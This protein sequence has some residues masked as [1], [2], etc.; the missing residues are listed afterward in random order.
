MKLK[1]IQYKRTWYKSS[2]CFSFTL[3]QRKVTWNQIPVGTFALV[4]AAT[5]ALMPTGFLLGRGGQRAAQF[6]YNRSL[7]LLNRGSTRFGW[8]GP[9][10]GL[11]V[12]SLRRGSRHFDI[13]FTG[14]RSGANA[15]RDG[16]YSGIIG[17]GLSSG[18]ANACSLQQ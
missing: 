1:M 11:D 2:W 16:I 10:N 17:G 7:G 5:S 8:S 12:L 13:P 4:G 15:V 14:L 18:G 3:G 6:G 9:K